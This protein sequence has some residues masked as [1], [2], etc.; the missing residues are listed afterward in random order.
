MKSKQIV[1]I[2]STA[3]EELAYCKNRL[4]VEFMSME[5]ATNLL[6]SLV[7]GI[8]SAFKGTEGLVELP[9]ILRRTVVTLREYDDGITVN[10]EDE[11]EKITSNIIQSEKY[12]LFKSDR[13]KAQ[14]LSEHIVKVRR[15]FKQKMVEMIFT[16]SS[17]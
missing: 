14:H 5:P 15:Y 17:K 13:E 9:Q 6:K 8:I 12:K 10:E 2:Q 4:S 1:Q 3:M 11:I 7:P 16:K